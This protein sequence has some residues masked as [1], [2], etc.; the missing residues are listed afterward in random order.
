MEE[1]RIV[2]TDSIDSK[3]FYIA[4]SDA[5][6]SFYLSDI[7]VAWN[8]MLLQI[9][10]LALGVF[11]RNSVTTATVNRVTYLYYANLGMFKFDNVGPLGVTMV[12]QA[13]T[14]ITS[15][16]V[17][18]VVASSGYLIAYTKDSIAWSSTLVPTDFVPSQVTG[19]GG[20]VVAGLDGDIIFATSNSLGVLIY[21][22]NN[23]VAGTYTG[24]ALFPFKFREVDNS[25]G[26]IDLDNTAWQANAVGQFVYTKAGLQSVSSQKATTIL[27]EVTDFLSGT[28][29]EDYNETT[30][31]LEVTNIPG[32]SYVTQ[33]IRK[34]KLVSARYLILSYGLPG[35]VFTH[36]I[37]VDTVLNKIG[38]FKIAHVDVFE[39]VQDTTIVA[40]QSIAFMGSRGKVDIVDFSVDGNHTGVLI[41]GKLQA[42][43]T[44]GLGLMGASVENVIE[45]DTLDF[46]SNA[47]LDGKNFTN[48]PS[49]LVSTAANVRDYAF[50]SSAL[51]HNLTFI[52][53]FN[54]V[55]V[56]IAYRIEGRR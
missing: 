8:T 3:R 7:G 13:T 43:R 44:R 42:T 11:D 27:P 41:L 45:G 16:D 33:L 25:R 39:Y 15:A 56:Q 1:V 14:G 12:V 6:Y 29:F 38:K 22:V 34:V 35:T 36:A 20:G 18:G 4:F 54:L 37:V 5:G 40:K 24:N 51:T 49:Y 2:F 48:V 17:L 32:F 21:T 46:F 50:R 31:Q 9:P 23:I 28:R 30:K 19:A 10:G 26:G 52:G 53:S 55:T 47:S